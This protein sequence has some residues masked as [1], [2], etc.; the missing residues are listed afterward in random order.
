MHSNAV[1]YRP[2]STTVSAI[3]PLIAQKNPRADVLSARTTRMARSK[4]TP[5]QPTFKTD[6]PSSRQPNGS[7]YTCIPPAPRPD[8]HAFLPPLPYTAKFTPFP[9]IPQ[10]T[11]AT[12][13]PLTSL[14]SGS[15]S[16]DSTFCAPD[17]ISG[18]SSYSQYL[19]GAGLG[20]E[21]LE[22]G[23][24]GVFDGL[25]WLSDG[26]RVSNS[27]SGEENLR[28]SSDLPCVCRKVRS[29]PVAEP[30]KRDDVFCP[31][32]STS[33]SP[34]SFLAWALP[35]TGKLAFY[36]HQRDDAGS[37]T[38]H[39]AMGDPSRATVSTE[40]KRMAGMER[41]A[42]YDSERVGLAWRR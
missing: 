17:V 9:V 19:P 12:T 35:N 16:D 11:P 31:Y 26:F 6:I 36:I 21:G 42:S 41:R 28:R 37:P 1:Q 33:L 7:H 29:Q 30:K 32:H 24:G 13:S 10:T 20:F 8:I 18:T 2:A 3:S 39:R 14:S 22:K 4:N 25:G 40:L 27:L 5:Y 23:G 38:M 15:R 34:T